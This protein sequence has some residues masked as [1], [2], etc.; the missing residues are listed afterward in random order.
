M[1]RDSYVYISTSDN[2]RKMKNQPLF[3]LG[4]LLFLLNGCAFQRYIPQPLS[5]DSV[6]S[7][8]Q[9]RTLDNPHLQEFLR[10]NLPSR[11]QAL[12]PDY[13]DEKTLAYVAFY[14]HPGL[15]VAR[16]QLAVQKDRLLTARQRPNPGV[17]F[18]L[19]Y[20]YDIGK[21]P[22][23]PWLLTPSLNFTIETAGKRKYR[24]NQGQSLVEEARLNVREVAW[25]V[26]S[27]QRLQLVNYLLSEEDLSLLKEEVAVRTEYVDSLQTLFSFGEIAVTDMEVARIDLSD[28]R[29][30]RITQEG[31]VAENRV[32]LANSLGL[33][34]TVLTN[35]RFAFEK[36]HQPPSPDE[37]SASHL[38][39]E[40]LV[41]NIS[42]RRALTTYAVAETSLQLEIARQYPDFQIGSSLRFF[43]NQRRWQIMPGTEL[44]VF[45]QNQGPIAEAKANR[46]TAGSQFL[47]LQANV[48]QD[49]ERIAAR[50]HFQLKNYETAQTLLNISTDRE[51][52][53]TELFNAGDLTYLD[54]L[55]ARLEKVLARQGVLRALFQLQTTLSE[56]ENIVQKPL[57]GDFGN[58]PDIEVN[59]REKKDSAE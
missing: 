13:W 38:Q 55:S 28:T 34:A 36:L 3:Y 49:M 26:K 11:G 46:E 31:I 56:L 35:H 12:P 33:P 51:Q 14:Y 10:E 39:R 59:P 2:Q 6:V 40:M 5:I 22:L 43:Q 24:I 52:E 9:G 57:D 23:N 30:R 50:Y 8:Y 54:V 37:L 27:R 32:L 29:L 45:N 42:L 41:N 20:N 47:Q 25:Q 4:G 44:P 19:G 58:L 15:D 7:T 21:I 1:N 48:L 16:S 53:I 17:G 18:N